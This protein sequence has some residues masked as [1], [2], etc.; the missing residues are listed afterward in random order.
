MPEYTV[1]KGLDNIS[2]PMLIETISTNFYFFL[3]WGLLEAGNYF[4]VR[5]P[6]SGVYGQNEHL[7]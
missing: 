6:T 7:S 1:L 2:D 3:N 5:I 4:N